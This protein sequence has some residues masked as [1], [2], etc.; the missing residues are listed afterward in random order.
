MTTTNAAHEPPNPVHMSTGPHTRW[1]TV[2]FAEAIHGVQTPLSWSFWTEISESATRVIFHNMGVFRASEVPVPASSDGRV[3][4]IFYGRAVGNVDTFRYVA[5]CTIGNSGDVVEQALFGAVSGSANLRER[6]RAYSRYPFVAVKLPH[7]AW[8][9][10][11]DLPRLRTEIRGWWQDRVLDHPPSTLEGAQQLMRDAMDQYV[12]AAVLSGTCTMIGSQLLGQL[13]GLAQAAADDPALMSDLATGY[14][15]ME[16]MGLISDLQATAR[17][18]LDLSEFIRRHGYHGPTEGDI[19][20][21]SWREDPSL[22]DG[23]LESYRRVDLTSPT[24]RAQQQTVKREA[25]E[26]RVLAGLPARRQPQ[27]RMIMRL[28]Q[29][30]IPLREAGKAAYLHGFD[31]G[32]CAARTMGELLAA[33]GALAAPDDVYFLTFSELTGVLAPNARELVAQRRADHERYQRLELPASWTGT[34]TPAPAA[35][36]SAIADEPVKELQGIGIVGERVTGRA[37]VVHDPATAVLE[38]G[39]IL[40][41]ATTDP[42]WTPLFMVA[43]ALVIDIGGPIS[44]GAI[45]ARELGIT[46]VINTGT[47]TQVIPDGATIAVDGKSG[48]VEIIDQATG[49]VPT[50]AMQR[51]ETS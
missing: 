30:F 3:C 19:T 39:D 41:C 27:A 13:A 37:R 45:V 2:N 22:L 14:G 8:R 15:G 33:Q 49:P 28:A 23:V 7:A 44:H 5:D 40:V 11:R 9:A 16:E 43:T 1:T 4:A 20:T 10:A 34:P 32:R 18:T 42:S 24:E 47:G 46:C 31:A 51:E 6:V 21:A 36:R 29:R 35:E 48:R 50:P 38:D 12:R 17:G 25:A 26:R